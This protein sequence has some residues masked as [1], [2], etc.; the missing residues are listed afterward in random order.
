MAP[1]KKTGR[2]AAEAAY[3][4]LMKTQTT[5]VGNVGAAFE[6]YATLLAAASAA[7]DL[8]EEARTAAIKGQAISADQL[9]QLG[10]KKTQRLPQLAAHPAAAAPVTP[11]SPTPKSTQSNG[12][13]TPALA[14]ASTDGG[15]A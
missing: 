5:L 14:G 11:S 9:D 1:K 6:E 15:T 3:A 12:T 4:D 10:Y 8:Y 2:A 13:P 7:R